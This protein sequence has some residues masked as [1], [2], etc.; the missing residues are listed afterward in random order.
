MVT[1]VSV[2]VPDQAQNVALNPESWPTLVAKVMQLAVAFAGWRPE[3]LQS[4]S[5]A[6]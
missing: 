3:D 5:A 2:S 1:A 4:I 6:A